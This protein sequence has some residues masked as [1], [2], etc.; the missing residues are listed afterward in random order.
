MIPDV[1]AFSRAAGMTLVLELKTGQKTEREAV[2]ELVAYDHEIRNH[3]PFSS[4]RDQCLVVIATEFGTLLDHA[5]AGLLIWQDRSVLCLRVREAEGRISLEVHMPRAWT[6]IGQGVLPP[7]AIQTVSLALYLDRDA[8]EA[9]RDALRNAVPLALDL[10]VRDAERAGSHGFA[11]TWH[12][13]TLGAELVL[14]VAVMDPYAFLEHA[15]VRGFLDVN[16]DALTKWYADNVGDQG[17]PA[18][19]LV[20]PERAKAFLDHYCTADF[21]SFV[22]WESRWAELRNR[23][24]VLEV[25][26]WGVLG[27]FAR[28]RF[29]HPFLALER[30][31]E[32]GMADT[33]RSPTFAIP[34]LLELCGMSLFRFGRFGVAEIFAFARSLAGLVAAADTI[35]A[36]T[37]QDLKNLP[38]L[39]QWSTLDVLPAIRAVNVR[40]LSS[41]VSKPPTLILGG[42]DRAAQIRESVDNF[43]TWLQED[44]LRDNPLPARM[45]AL[46]ASSFALFDEYF[47]EGLDDTYRASLIRTI[48]QEAC[49]IVRFVLVDT[50]GESTDQTDELR[51]ARLEIRRLYSTDPE[52]TD[53]VA[54]SEIVARDAADHVDRFPGLLDAADD[55]IPPVFHRLGT[56]ASMDA[57]W[58]WLRAEVAAARDR[59]ILC[60]GLAVADDGTISTHNF[61]AWMARLCAADD[62]VLLSIGFSGVSQIKVVRWTDLV[63]GKAFSDDAQTASH[64]ELDTSNEEPSGDGPKS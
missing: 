11:F 55:I 56:P 40:Y 22:S 37:E 13:P 45:F 35:A 4:H 53:A 3:L 16:G 26:S 17:S 51:A 38:A 9:E 20:I 28:E 54:C 21:E 34:L 64:D 59:G 36:Y 23:G 43:M 19:L 50:Q 44:F 47:S 25:D 30:G 41:D 24:Y 62:E 60:P 15:L 18:S 42:P 33:W 63:S 61:P 46:G 32:I 2:T 10:L 12:N 27:E 6:A 7:A 8:G 14:T 48:G 1:V 5:V 31:G 52:L 57:D 29:V 49:A 39:L 58:P